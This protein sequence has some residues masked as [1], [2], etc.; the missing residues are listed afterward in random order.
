MEGAGGPG[1]RR[2]RAVRRRGT[3]GRG[4]SAG[5]EPREG[6]PAATG[7]GRAAKAAPAGGRRP[8][9]SAE[10]GGEA[11]AVPPLRLRGVLSQL[12]LGRRDVSEASGLVNQVVSHLIQA[13][14]GRDGGFGSIGRLGAGSY[15]ERVKVGAGRP[16]PRG[17]ARPAG[18]ALSTGG[19]LPTQLQAWQRVLFPRSWFL[20]AKGRPLRTHL[21]LRAV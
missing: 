14:R 7:R 1:E 6:G 2:Q 11:A 10:R 9:G 3:A 19:R 13:I 16:R 12:S 20:S 15:Y 18:P 5:G 8:G 21:A 4:S 17:W